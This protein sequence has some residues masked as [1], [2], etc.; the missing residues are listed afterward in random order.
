MASFCGPLRLSRIYETRPQ[1]VVD[2][3]YYLNAVGEAMSAIEPRDMMGRLHRIEHDF[4]R[5][6]SREIRNGPR[7]LDLDI[8]LCDEMVISTPDLTI[9][10]PRILERLFVLIPLLE[11]LPHLADPR[12]AIPYARSLLALASDSQNNGGSRGAAD[13]GV[14]LYSPAGYSTLP[15]KEP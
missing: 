10:H 2:Q 5:D 13:R 11:L 4:G 9:P 14:Y 1:Y 6:R 15:N 12:T 8:L 3:P 7:T